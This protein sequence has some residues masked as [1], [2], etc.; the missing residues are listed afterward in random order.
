[1]DIGIGRVALVTGGARGIGRAVAMKLAAPDTAI[2]FTHVNPSSPGAAETLALLKDRTGAAEAQCW[3]AEDSVAAQ[4]HIE[5]IVSRYGRLDVL[6]NNAGLTRDNLSVRLSDED[7]RAVLEANLFGAFAC[8]RPAAKVMMKQ[9][10]GRI[11]NLSS[12]VAFSGNPGQANYCASKAG[13]VGLTK[14]MALELA[15]RGVTVNAVAPGFIATD[16]T[17]KLD[18]KLRESFVGRIP[19]GRFGSPEDVA[20]VVAFLA[21]DGAAYVTGQTIHV[22]GGLYL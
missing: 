8:S 15:S 13:L 22:N 16:M 10:R 19:A 2:V 6:V 14:S 5:D 17:S 20:E 4:R 12:V 18:E 3:A 1:M 7:W 11:I 21:G 9:R